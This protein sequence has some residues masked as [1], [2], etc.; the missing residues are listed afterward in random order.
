MDLLICF[1]GSFWQCNKMLSLA[2]G[3]IFLF[4]IGEDQA[5]PTWQGK[6]LGTNSK[7]K[8]NRWDINTAK[9]NTH[10]IQTTVDQAV[11]AHTKGDREQKPKQ[12]RQLALV[13]ANNRCP[14]LSHWET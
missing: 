9:Q 14:K 10:L 11:R 4:H 5:R 13:I 3:G 12:E 7:R 8:G 1:D 6:A 2:S